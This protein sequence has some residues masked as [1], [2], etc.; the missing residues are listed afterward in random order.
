MRIFTNLLA[1]IIVLFVKYFLYKISTFSSG[2]R[3]LF[4]NY[5]LIIISVKLF[6]VSYVDLLV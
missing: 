1:V 2:Q 4:N 6:V 5:Y 3:S